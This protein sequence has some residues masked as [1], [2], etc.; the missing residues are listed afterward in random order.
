MVT[1]WVM[2]LNLA[3]ETV[4]S[5]LRHS[6]FQSKGKEWIQTDTMKPMRSVLV[7]HSAIRERSL[8]LKFSATV[9]SIKALGSGVPVIFLRQPQHFAWRGAFFLPQKLAALNI[10]SFGDRLAVRQNM[11]KSRYVEEMRGMAAGFVMVP[12]ISSRLGDT[13][14]SCGLHLA[15]T[16]QEATNSEMPGFRMGMCK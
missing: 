8:M 15:T 6:K 9:R 5:A 7:A 16:A 1:S 2:M 4:F 11:K 3:S 14:G 13:T 10:S 12:N